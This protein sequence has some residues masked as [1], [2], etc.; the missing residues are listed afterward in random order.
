VDTQGIPDKVDIA[1]V[2]VDIVEVKVDMVEVRVDT[3]AVMM[4]KVNRQTTNSNTTCKTL[5]PEMTS[6]MKNNVKV[7]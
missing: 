3:V 5:N 6:V 4:T 7:T 1:E 2:K